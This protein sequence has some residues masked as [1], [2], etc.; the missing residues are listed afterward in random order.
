[1]PTGSATYIIFIVTLKIADAY[2][3]CCHVTI[4]VSIQSGPV[5]EL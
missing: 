5:L 3:Y 4:N 1:M 2:V